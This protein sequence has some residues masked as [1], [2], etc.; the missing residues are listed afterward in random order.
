MPTEFFKIQLYVA[1]KHYPLNCKRVEEGIYRK[2][3]TNINEK[4]IKYSSAFPAAELG[5]RDLLA[6]AAID[7][8]AENLKIKQIQD[9]SPVFDKIEA[10]DKE[11]EEY[12]KVK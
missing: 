1:E 8:S 9:V 10:L 7:I 2:A 12:L 3:A 6:M 5:L 11:L 4:I